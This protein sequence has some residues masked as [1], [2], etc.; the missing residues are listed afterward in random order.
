MK[1]YYRIMLGRKSKYA[2][3]ARDGNF[4]GAD[5]AIDKDLSNS[6][7]EEFR[8][9]NKEFIPLFLEKHPD[10]KKIAAGLA[11]G[12]L[13]T[14]AKGVKQ[15]DIVICPDGSGSY[16][17]GEVRGGYEKKKGKIF[18][19]RRTVICFNRSITREVFSFFVFVSSAHFTNII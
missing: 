4:I 17:V 5:F 14:I 10:K 9:F 16:Y 12:M 2:K 19:H 11:C 3:E 15:G 8:A 7:P 18:P 13:W 1:N 6:L